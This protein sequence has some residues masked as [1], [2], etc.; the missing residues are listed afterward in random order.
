M[1][2]FRESVEGISQAC[3][4]LEIPVVGGNV[5]FYNETD[6][7]DIHPTPVVGMLGL[8]DPMPVS[9]PR[10]SR[11]GEGMEVWEI[12][13]AP[14]SN[15]AGSTA[16]RVLH[17]ELTGRPTLPD[18]ET[19]GRVIHLAAELAHL[20]PILHDVSDGGRLVAVAEICIASEVGATLQAAESSVLFSEDPHRFIAVFEPGT[21]ELPADISRRVGTIEGDSL[22]LAGSVPIDIGTL[23]ETHRNAIP[24]LMAG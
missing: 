15:L 18:A 23:I 9:P 24:R 1:W 2:Q 3:E 6:G 17:N 14:T 7:D 5:S 20:V 21:V 16:Q 22:A 12:G 10:L 8:A 11:A 19:A 4:S 13:P